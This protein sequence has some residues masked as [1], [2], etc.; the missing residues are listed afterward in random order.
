[1][2]LFVRAG[3]NLV[4]VLKTIKASEMVRVRVMSVCG[5][6]CFVFFDAFA[7]NMSCLVLECYITF[8]LTTFRLH[9]HM[10]RNIVISLLKY[11]YINVLIRSEC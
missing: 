1:M 3:V 11:L 2:Q 9:I 8:E 5:F 4:D 7:T 10:F 6:F